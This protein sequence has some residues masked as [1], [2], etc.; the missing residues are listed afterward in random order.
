MANPL[1]Y[2]F[3][4]INTE[5]A[6]RWLHL[7]PEDDGPVWMLNLMKY[8]PVADYGD[9]ATSGIS[10][11]EADDIYAP[12]AVLDDL[13]ATMPLFGDVTLQVTDDVAWER[14]GIVRYPSRASFFA[15]QN[16]DDFQ[17]QYV[18]KEA[19]METTI[20]M[21]C[22]PAEVADPA[23]AGS[24]PLVMR[25]RRFIEGADPGA[26]PAGVVPVARFDVDGVILGDG[27]VWDDV[28]FDRVDDAVLP[29]LAATEGI[30]EQVIVVV[31][32]L[33]EDLIGSV[34]TAGN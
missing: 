3:G 16:R 14:I 21:G 13:G 26:D 28:R 23:G 24:G 7:A 22:V 11:R 4:T 8:K 10:G 18:H 32:P 29:L 9:G 33:L 12:T 15:M 34:V 27:R 20:V 6:G 5:T 25:V 1:D 31:D 19:G 2:P 30:A 17:K